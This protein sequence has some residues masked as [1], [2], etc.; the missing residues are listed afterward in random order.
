MEAPI[1]NTQSKNSTAFLITLNQ[2]DRFDKLKEYLSSFSSLVYAIAG[3]ETAPST[4]HKHIHVF[5]QFAKSRRLSIR[6]LEGAHVDK[7]YGSPIQNRDYVKKEGNIIWEFGQIRCGGLCRISDIY[8][9]SQQERMFLPLQYFN[10][11][12]KV[13]SEENQKLLTINTHKQV[14]AYYISGNSGIGKT[15][16]ATYLIGKE[17]YNIVKYENGFWLGVTARIR[18]ALYDDWRDSHMRASEFLNFIDYNKQIMNVKGGFMLNN[19][20]IIIITSILDLKNIYNTVS[21]E[22]RVQ[23]E[24]R[25]KEIHLSTV[26]NDDREKHLR[27]LCITIKRYLRVYIFKLLKN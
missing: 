17:P 10:I 19:Y 26:Y 8:S 14:K 15:R 20:E 1:A 4:G 24:R 22:S 12:Q 9:M 7:C 25:L 6:K 18:I 13:N 2:V 21:G 23:W 16:F 11:V 5:I 27:Y 3:L